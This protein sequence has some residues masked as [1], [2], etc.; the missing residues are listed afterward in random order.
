MV[1]QPNKNKLRPFLPDILFLIVDW[2]IFSKGR[3]FDVSPNSKLFWLIVVRRG[4]EELALIHTEANRGLIELYALL[5]PES[6]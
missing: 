1:Y 5:W 4:T 3:N 2:S 6:S